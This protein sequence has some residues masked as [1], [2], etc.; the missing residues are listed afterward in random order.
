MPERS[1]MQIRARSMRREAT[2]AERVLWNLLHDRRL[3]G[4]KFRRQV[5]LGPYIADFACFSPG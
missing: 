1:E 4:L 2:K 3:G 5:L